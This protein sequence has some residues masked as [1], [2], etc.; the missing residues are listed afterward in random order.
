[1]KCPKCGYERQPRDHVFVPGTECPACGIVY[2]KYATDLLAAD[3]NAEATSS[4][5]KKPSPVHEDSLRQARE[6]VERRLRAKLTVGQPDDHRGEVL[7]RAK[8]FASEGVRQ[9]QEEW[10]QSKPE[11]LDHTDNASP[12]AVTASQSDPEPELSLA[13]EMDSQ[14]SESAG[15]DA[16]AESAAADNQGEETSVPGHL[17]PV[18]QPREEADVVVETATN[19]TD[20]EMAAVASEETA[21]DEQEP[22]A[23]TE[24]AAEQH[25]WESE[26]FHMASEGSDADDMP[27]V[28]ATAVMADALARQPRPNGLMRLLPTVAWL[29][30]VAGIVGAILSWTTLG[31]VYA[32]QAPAEASAYNNL[33]VALLLGFAYLATGVLGFAF[34]WVSS[35][36]NTQLKEI[37]QLIML[38]PEMDE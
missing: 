26:A 10:R 28:A 1:M 16:T 35:M 17:M 29:I 34:F 36:I 38:R 18:D 32:G 12:D 14:I 21:S 4:T 23:H 13:D 3:Q 5:I 19:E 20:D 9:R 2:S 25:E 6:R 37:R 11:N 7:A 8:L 15:M 30:L 31:D 27:G 33:P 22:A 24:A